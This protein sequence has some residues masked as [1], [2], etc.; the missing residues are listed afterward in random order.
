MDSPPHVIIVSRASRGG[1]PLYCAE[2]A[3]ALAGEGARVGLMQP[4][5][6][7]DDIEPKLGDLPIERHEIPA[8]DSGWKRQELA[9]AKTLVALRGPGLVIFEDTSPLR[10]VLLSML[11]ARTSWDLASMV[12]NTRPHS[13]SR[14][15]RFRHQ[16]GMLA[17]AV[18][19]R[20]LVHNDRQRQEISS[21]RLNRS[22]R[23]D[24]VPHGVWTDLMVDRDDGTAAS[25][26]DGSRL[27]V[28]GVMRDNTGLDKLVELV[29]RLEADFPD[30][31]VSVIGKPSSEG[32][33]AVLA[34][35][36]SMK[37][38]TVRSEFVDESEISSIFDAHDFLLLPYENYSSE[39]GVLMQAIAYGLPVITAGHTSISER[40]AELGLGPNPTGSLYEQIETALNAGPGTRSEWIAK[41]DLAASNLT[42]VRQ[43]QII[44]DGRPFQDR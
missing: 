25:K 22:S 40:V 38:V 1:H 6:A 36:G 34:V 44:L 4:A 42:W 29:P 9:I 20:V 23:I 35:L 32:V 10:A 24:V 41:I 21:Y 19:H 8:I 33:E 43:A 26:R 27:L 37:A 2:L 14:R 30:L 28:F 7:F 39:S 12:H 11:K 17:L 16:L 15:A 31:H 3:R 5:A 13:R 18:P